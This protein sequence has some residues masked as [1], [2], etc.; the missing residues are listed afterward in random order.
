MSC[1]LEDDLSHCPHAENVYGRY[2]DLREVPVEEREETFAK[3]WAL[4]R[5]N[6]AAWFVSNCETTSVRSM[7]VGA[8]QGRVQTSMYY[9]RAVFV[10]YASF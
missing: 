10:S 8:A 4:G 5:P 2:G 1:S 9:R 6:K 7:W 3:N